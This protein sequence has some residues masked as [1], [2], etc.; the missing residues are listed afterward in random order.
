MLMTTQNSVIHMAYLLEPGFKREKSGEKNAPERS[1]FPT[2]LKVRFTG[3]T[4]ESARYDPKR[5]DELRS[6]NRRRKSTSRNSR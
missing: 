5:I 4:L 2:F 1:A 3:K 6:A